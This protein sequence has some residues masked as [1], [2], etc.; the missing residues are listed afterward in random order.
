[1][2]MAKKGQVWAGMGRN[3]AER[4]IKT[5]LNKASKKLGSDLEFII[6]H[7]LFRMKKF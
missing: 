7:Q 2:K 3:I 5:A 4:S 6:C 1:M